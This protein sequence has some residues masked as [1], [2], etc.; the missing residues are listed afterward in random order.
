MAPLYV[1]AAVLAAPAQADPVRLLDA[2]YTARLCEAWNGTSLPAALGRSGSGWIDS[3]GSEG[4][5]VIVISRR[6]CEGWPK[7]QL[8]IEADEAGQAVCRSGG[9]FPGG[10]LQ[11]RFTPTTEQWADFSDGFGVMQMPG[12]MSGFIGPY[13]VAAANIGNFE[14]F[15]AAAGR[16]A[17]E[18]DVDWSCD[19]ADAEDVAEEVADIDREDMAA[20]LK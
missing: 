18:L 8:V 19:G 5:Q 16:L 10:E 12:I 11:W 20:I 15:F 17:L 4:R 6:D 3:A 13:P 14:V 9:A 7:V 1:L 2:P